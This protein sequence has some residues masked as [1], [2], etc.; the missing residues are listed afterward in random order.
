[1]T[2]KEPTRLGDW[3]TAQEIDQLFFNYDIFLKDDWTDV[4]E[5]IKEIVVRAIKRHERTL[6]RKGLL[7]ETKETEIQKGIEKNA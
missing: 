2:T 1:M 4:S 7:M 3:Q 5:T 6:V